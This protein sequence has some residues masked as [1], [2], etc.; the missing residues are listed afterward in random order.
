MT[1]GSTQYNSQFDSFDA[2]EVA[3]LNNHL[4]ELVNQLVEAET[5]LQSM[6]AVAQPGDPP[7]S[8]DKTVPSMA[9]GKDLTGDILHVKSQIVEHTASL[10]RYNRLL[11]EEAAELRERVTQRTHALDA[12]EARFRIVFEDSVL[13]IALLDGEGNI[14]DANPAMQDILGYRAE[15]LKEMN[16]ADERIFQNSELLHSLIRSL[17]T[18]A[19]KS[20]QKEDVY[21]SSE[22]RRRW[23]QLILST[24]DP[25]R[26]LPFPQMIATLQ[27]ISEKKAA[28]EALIRSERLS[29]AGQLGTSL[30]HEINNPIQSVIGCLG[31]AEEL[32]ENDGKIREYL[33][34][35]IEELVRTAGIA[36][37]LRDLGRISDLV[38]KQFVDLNAVLDRVVFLTREKCKNRGVELVWTPAPNLPLMMVSPDHIHQVFL[39]LVLNALDAMPEGGRFA[40]TT[41]YVGNP[42]GV[43]ITFADE[44]KGI[45][46][47]LLA[48][49]FEPFQSGRP[50]GLGLGLYISRRIVEAHH[51]DISIESSPGE[52]T[53]FTVWLPALETV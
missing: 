34:I 39:N 32:L 30:A 22:G 19:M 2:S 26:S 24:V 21:F 51:G 8:G 47:D 28:Q 31:L 35:A 20:V 18:G 52:G 5:V 38:E 53:I 17:N 40:V 48:K 6:L 33:E 7:S 3:A 1:S 37:R 15:E 23:G 49:L 25:E 9:A 16:L 43:R 50:E 42:K 10:S 14:V 11:R 46:P 4:F 27:D 41:S 36:Q 12:S 13:G 45:E 29:L 44:G